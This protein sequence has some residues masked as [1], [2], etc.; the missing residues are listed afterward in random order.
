MLGKYVRKPTTKFIF[1]FFLNVYNHI[2]H[3][4]SHWPHQIFQF[5]QV[6]L[7]TKFN[8]SVTVA[9]FRCSTAI[10]PSYRTGVPKSCKSHM[11]QSRLLFLLLS[12]TDKSTK[13]H[14]KHTWDCCLM[15]ICTL[16]MVSSNIRLRKD[17]GGKTF[18]RE[19]PHHH[20]KWPHR[21]KAGHGTNCIR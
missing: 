7:H 12:L 13:R 9:V 14:C 1:K 21:H 19:M 5:I 3:H 16:V 20:Q 6:K 2:I 11:L 17:L 15:T 10:K 8:A 18:M 4:S